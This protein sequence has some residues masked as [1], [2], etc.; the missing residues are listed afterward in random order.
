MPIDEA[1]QSGGKTM[2]QSITIH[3]PIPPL[4]VRPNSRTHWRVKGR[5]NKGCRALSNLMC[6]EALAG[7]KSPM[8]SK[9]TIQIEAR[10]KTWKGMDPDN[11]CAS[12][13]GYT[14]GIQDAGIVANDNQLWPLRPVIITRSKTP[15]ITLTITP[16]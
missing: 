8:W 16:E 6:K 14:D 15:G 11:L 10:F 7:R 12:I 3:L 13:K 2:I 4:A 5:A 1:R 9:A